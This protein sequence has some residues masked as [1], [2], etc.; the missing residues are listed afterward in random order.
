MLPPGTKRRTTRVRSLCESTSSPAIA[1]IG[2][3]MNASDGAQDVSDLP[4][5]DADHH[6]Q[7]GRENNKPRFTYI[8]RS[9]RFQLFARSS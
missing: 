6:D 1:I 2:S 7:H 9:T 5:H 8:Q 4:D 3:A